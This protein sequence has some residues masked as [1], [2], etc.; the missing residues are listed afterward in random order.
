MPKRG[1]AK[2]LAKAESELVPPQDPPKIVDAD[3]PGT[4]YIKPEYIVFPG[5]TT[6][7]TSEPGALYYRSDKDRIVYVNAGSAETTI[8]KVPVETADIADG[9]ITMPKLADSAV[10]TS[11][12]ED[13][14]ITTPK[15]ADSA[16][17]TGKIADY[18]V[19]TPKLDTGAVT[20]EKLADSAVTT[21]KLA[22]LAVT[23]AK[24]A[25]S[26]VSTAKIADEAV[27]DAKIKYPISPGKIGAGDLNI[28]TGT[29][30][31]GA[32]QVGD[33]GLKYGWAIRETPNS[34]VFIKDG[35]IVARL[36]KDLGFIHMR[37]GIL[38]WLLRKIMRKT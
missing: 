33:I 28:G 12:I 5:L 14:A 7:P 37:K 34:L 15:L 32:I 35:R 3:P 29:L 22:D 18:A 11:K 27:T 9:A 24:L 10:T 1:I 2:L 13:G 16:V 25:D 21:E 31:C 38:S 36:H 4:L 19:T 20:T 23:T 8:P 17:T 26:A 6:S 30:Y